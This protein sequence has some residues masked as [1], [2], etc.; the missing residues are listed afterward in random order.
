MRERSWR[1]VEEALA[2][3]A[4]LRASRGPLSEALLAAAIST[5]RALG[6]V[7]GATAADPSFAE[8]LGVEIDR[9][10]DELRELQRELPK[11]ESAA[12]V[13]GRARASRTR[14]DRR[15]QDRRKRDRRRRDRRR[16]LLPVDFD[17]RA[18]ERR[19]AV[20]RTGERRSPVD[21]R[22]AAA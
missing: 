18:G 11:F 5:A 15:Q 16:R 1:R 20:R 2:L 14:F 22:G 3:L 9:L 12:A 17:R 21:R 6:F 8:A 13:P 19:K 4:A 10:T 7:E